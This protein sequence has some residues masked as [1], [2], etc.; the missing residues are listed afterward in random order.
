M[1]AAVDVYG[2]DRIRCRNLA[3]GTHSS[4]CAH[5]IVR[6]S[7][8]FSYLPYRTSIELYAAVNAMYKNRVSSEFNK[9]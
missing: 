4:L 2:I 3:L 8:F 1:P 7:T 6:K 9:K 5:N